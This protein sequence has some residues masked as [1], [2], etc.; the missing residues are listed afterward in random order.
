MRNTEHQI[1]EWIANVKFK[2]KAFGGV[3]EMDVWKKIEELHSLYE[4]ALIAQRA[5]YEALLE[6]QEMWLNNEP[7]RKKVIS[8]K[9]DEHEQES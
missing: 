1:A 2:K 6:Q 9:K 7:R 5:H 8:R 3:D 4:Q